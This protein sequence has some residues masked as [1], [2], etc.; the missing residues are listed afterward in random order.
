LADLRQLPI[1]GSGTLSQG[2]INNIV[3]WRNAATAQLSASN[4]SYGS[5]T[6]DPITAKNWLNNFVNNN[7]TGFLN[8]STMTFGNP[9]RTDQGL[10]NRQE[11]ITLCGSLFNQ[12]ALQYLGTFSRELNRPTWKPVTPT[13]STI[14]YVTLAKTPTAETSTAINR[15]LTAVRDSNGNQLITTRFPLS[16]LSW[17]TYNGPSASRTMPPA[18]PALPVTDPNYDMWQLLYT[19]GIPQSYLLQGTAANIK[20]SFGLVWDSRTP[21]ATVGQQWVYTSPSSANSGGTF[22]GSTGN[23]ATVIKTL[24]TV[25]SEARQPDFF[26]FLKTVILNGSVGLGSG[27]STLNTFVISEAKYYSTTGGLSA[28]CQLL[29][30]GANIIDAWD[31]NNLPMFIGYGTNQG[32]S[33]FAQQFAGIEN[34]PYLNKLVFKPYWNTGVTPSTFDAWLLPSLWNPHQN[35]PPAAAPNVRINMTSGQMRAVIRSTS[36]TTLM[37]NLLTGDATS[38][39]SVSMIVNPTLSWLGTSPS[40]PQAVVGS[41]PSTVTQSTDPTPGGY[42]GFHFTFGAPGTITPAN[43]SN[44]YPD[45]VSPCTFEL[46]VQV[47]TSPSVWKT[48]QRWTG[49]AQPATRLVCQSPSSWTVNTLQDPEFVALDPRTQRFGAWGNDGSHSGS[50][51]AT[52]YTA[53][54]VT[55]LDRSSGGLELITALPPQGPKFTVSSFPA[56]L[57]LYSTNGTSSNHYVDLDGV[58]RRADWTTDPSGTS[59][60]KTIMYASPTTT[61]PGGNYTDR[62]QI[63]SRPFQSVAELGQV[64]R[65]QPWKTINFTTADSGDVGLLDAFTLQDVSM[66]AGKTSLNTRQTLVLTTILSQAALRLDGS[67]ILNSTQVTNLVTDI[68]SIT[69]ANPLINKSQLIAQLATKTSFTGLGN[70]EARECVVRALSDAG[71]T[72]TWNLMIDVI[73]QSGRYPPSATNLAQFVVEGEQRYWVHVAI[74]RF[75]GQVIDRQI[76]PVNQ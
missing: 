35:A 21:T 66:T 72:R 73:A 56:D 75:T 7:S 42:Y 12:D 6:F 40:A 43:S 52:D 55:T 5:Y 32:S 58:Q 59:S 15:D 4:G 71:Q 20:A 25:Q 41:P 44:A 76:E 63:L 11:L 3:G 24:T 37:S 28:D 60:T 23:G 65:D 9:V 69:A 39:A 31:T 53:G 16:R 36:G 19:Y 22:N 47:S 30:I 2:Q 67:S 50:G 64:F 13:G 26:E 14:D 61:P 1:G 29:Q 10:L 34:L 70:K 45:F 46:Q 27:S 48:Y 8:V 74:D 17:I 68:A 38:T 54:A 57:S 33:G 51:S 62:P 49:C 18:S